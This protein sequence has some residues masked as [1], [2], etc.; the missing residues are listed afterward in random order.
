MTTTKTAFMYGGKVTSSGNIPVTIVYSNDM[1][2]NWITSE[3]SVSFDADYFYIDFFDENHG[4]FVMGYA[5][6]VD[7]EKYSI[8]RTSNG[9][10]DWELI[11]K[12]P[13]TRQI[14]GARYFNEDVGFLL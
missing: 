5:K 9:G 10:Q 2:K 14:V 8:Y 3:I 12:G 11:G 4:V 7:S 1:G 13:D 6:D